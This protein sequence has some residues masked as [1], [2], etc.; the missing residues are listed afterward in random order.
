MCTVVLLR[1]PG[2][3][4]PAII[5]ANRDEAVDRPWRPPARHW[6]DRPGVLAGLD[7]EAGGSWMGLNEAGVAAAILNRRGSLG[8]EAGKRTRGALVL[9]ALDHGTA[10]DAAAAM[11]EVDGRAYRSFNMLVADREHA[12]WI[13]H[14]GRRG[15]SAHVLG[16]GLSMLTAS[17]LNDRAASE[18][19]DHYLPR[20]EAARPP[21]PDAPDGWAEWESLLLSEET[22]PGVLDP[23]GAM[24]VRTGWG[25]ATVSRA[26]LALPAGA[27]ARPVWRFARSWPETGGYTE[28]H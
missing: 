24:H 14:A 3:A 11:T 23:N 20:F 2:H 25:F 5:A 22:A 8:P 15:V 18:R 10:E 12:F 17:D 1:R 6:P 7:E 19:I 9:E 28:L 21:D 13:R 4:W 26:L 16:P 27:G